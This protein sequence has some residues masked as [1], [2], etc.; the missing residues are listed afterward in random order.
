MCVRLGIRL[1]E[2]GGL[3][4]ADGVMAAL[5]SYRPDE[6]LSAGLQAFVF[7][8][9]KTKIKVKVKVKVKVRVRVRGKGKG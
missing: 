3:R 6:K 5:R 4:C 9:V 2:C 1:G 8:K 7:A